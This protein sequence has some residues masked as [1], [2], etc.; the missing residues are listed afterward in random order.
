MMFIP[1]SDAERDEMLASI[2]IKSMDDLFE[3]IPKKYRFP[4]INLHEGM[5]EIEASAQLKEIAEADLSVEDVSCFMGAG[6]FII[7]FRLRSIT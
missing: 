5:T 7:I 6:A 3:A 2:G 1:H 4:K